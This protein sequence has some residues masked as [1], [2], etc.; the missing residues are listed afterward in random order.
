[1]LTEI[2]APDLVIIG[3]VAAI[4]FLVWMLVRFIRARS[5]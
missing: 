3:V 5:A 4:A 2:V 1:M